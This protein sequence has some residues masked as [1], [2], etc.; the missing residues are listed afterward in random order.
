MQ[1][2]CPPRTKN[3]PDLL[4]GSR[5]EALQANRP[6]RARM[7]GRQNRVGTIIRAGWAECPERRRRTS[8]TEIE[9]ICPCF[10]TEQRRPHYRAVADA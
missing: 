3:L 1:I 4:A 8:C 2:L 9:Q 7:V 6:N 10:L 5:G